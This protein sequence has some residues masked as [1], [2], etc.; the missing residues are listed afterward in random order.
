M[1]E[2]QQSSDLAKYSTFVNELASQRTSWESIRDHHGRNVLHKAVENGN[3]LLVKTLVC[4]G[5][6]INVKEKCGATP[7]ML[8]VINKNEEMCAY[9]LENFAVFDYHF[10]STIPSPHTV[11]VSLHLEGA[12]IMDKNPSKTVT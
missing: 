4:A 12:K 5:V 2:A 3:M 8:A 11:A 1:W 7:L 9:L 6:D 10:F